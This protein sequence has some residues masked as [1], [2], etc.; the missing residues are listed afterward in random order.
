MKGS[1]M[2]D[3]VPV[4]PPHV[5]TIPEL[6]DIVVNAVLARDDEEELDYTSIQAL[7]VRSWKVGDTV[8]NEFIVSVLSYSEPDP[9]RGER[10]LIMDDS[11]VT[12]ET[13]RVV[14][15]EY[16][17]IILDVI[18]RLALHTLPGTKSY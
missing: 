7:Y 4:R 6:T 2:S 10:M 11:M 16:G 15:N 17:G 18:E 12:L 3:R 5:H 14:I 8:L 9:D 13:V 1:A